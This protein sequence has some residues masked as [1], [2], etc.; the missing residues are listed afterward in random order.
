MMISLDIKEDNKMFV[1]KGNILVQSTGSIKI[2]GHFSRQYY[3]DV[4]KKCPT[5]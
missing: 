4:G 1:R 3:K 5:Y 2:L